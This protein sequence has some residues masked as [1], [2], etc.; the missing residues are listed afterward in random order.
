MK[1]YGKTFRVSKVHSARNC[2]TCSEQVNGSRSTMRGIGNKGI[3][4]EL[5]RLLIVDE[6]QHA[7]VKDELEEVKLTTCI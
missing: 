7:A 2:G 5:D 3:E 6:I 4:G 1:P